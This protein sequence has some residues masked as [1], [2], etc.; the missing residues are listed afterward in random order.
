[1]IGVIQEIDRNK[2]Q[3]ILSSLLCMIHGGEEI[4]LQMAGFAL[5]EQRRVQENEEM[6]ITFLARV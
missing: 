2:Q 4:H 3:P 5:H 6:R 1:M